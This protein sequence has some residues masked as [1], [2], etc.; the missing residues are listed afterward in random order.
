MTSPQIV[1]EMKRLAV[2]GSYRV[3]DT[4]CEPQ[5]DRIARLASGVL[6]CPI[7]LVSLVDRDRQWFKA[8]LGLAARETHRDVS[9]CSHAIMSEDVFVVEDAAAD[10]RFADNPLVTGQPRI[11]FYA[12]APLIAPCGYKIG[13]LCVIDSET[14]SLLPGQRTLLADLA[15]MVMDALELRRLKADVARAVA[16]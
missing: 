5:F 1:D 2:L 15:A 6:Q 4:E 12:G 9:F 14:H 7:S 3:L 13:T 8:H 16:A 10:P 11:K